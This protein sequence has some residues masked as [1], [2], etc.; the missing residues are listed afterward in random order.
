MIA[1]LGSFDCYM[2]SPFQ[3]QKKSVEKRIENIDTDVRV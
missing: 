3:Y 2:N 1:N